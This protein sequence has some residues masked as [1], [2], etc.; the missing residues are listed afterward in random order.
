MD[1]GARL[2]DLRQDARGKGDVMHSRC[3]MSP[4][5][6]NSAPIC[7]L[8]TGAE[9]YTP[10]RIKGAHRA[11]EK[12]GLRPDG[13]QWLADNVC[14]LIQTSDP[15]CAAVLGLLIPLSLAHA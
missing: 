10:A 6:H 11:L 3:L 1:A 4:R 2:P 5:L 12:M 9:D 15:C 8:Q 7:V 13:N 14:G